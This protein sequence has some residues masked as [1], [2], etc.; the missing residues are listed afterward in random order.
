MGDCVAENYEGWLATVMDVPPNDPDAF[1]A[2][3]W[4]EKFGRGKSATQNIIRKA[5]EKGMMIK[6]SKYVSNGTGMQ[7][8]AAYKM[9]EQPKGKAK[10]K[11]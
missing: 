3:E 9:V 10:V 5:L 7:A 4:M 6:M 11:K 1:T 8:V 2:K